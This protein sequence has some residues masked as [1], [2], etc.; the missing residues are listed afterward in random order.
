M[1]FHKPLQTLHEFKMQQ[2]NN[3][4]IFYYKVTK[5]QTKNPEWRSRIEGSCVTDPESPKLKD[6]SVIL[7]AWPDCT[8]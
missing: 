4:A 3:C 1:T 2:H 8:L 6:P 7:P 5:S